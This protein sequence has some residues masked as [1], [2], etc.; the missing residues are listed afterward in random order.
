MAHDD[1]TTT[2]QIDLADEFRLVKAISA[3][4]ADLDMERAAAESRR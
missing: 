2:D 3:L 1:T 4:V